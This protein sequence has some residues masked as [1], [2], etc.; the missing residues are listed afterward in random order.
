MAE[1]LTLEFEPA[2]ERLVG[3]VFH[4]KK[5]SLPAPCETCLANNGRCKGKSKCFAY[6]KW[7]SSGGK[8]L[9]LDRYGRSKVYLQPKN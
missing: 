9:E 1:Q 4:E 5:N 7:V 6:S 3:I 8:M 2:N